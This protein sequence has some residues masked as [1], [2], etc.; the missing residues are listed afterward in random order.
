MASQI[1][2]LQ[3]LKSEQKIKILTTMSR[4]FGLRIERNIKQYKFDI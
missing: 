2:W 4:N 1:V 3:Y